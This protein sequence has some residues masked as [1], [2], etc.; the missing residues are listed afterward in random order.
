MEATRPV[1]LCVL[2]CVGLLPPVLA[3][4][5]ISGDPKTQLLL[6][7]SAAVSACGFL[8]TKWLVPLVGAKTASRGIC[9]KD[10]N[11]R[12]TP[13]GERPVPEA[14]GLAVG[15]VFLLCII[16]FELLHYYDIGS[17]VRWLGS[18]GQ[19]G[20]I[21]MEQT[22][23]AWLVDY[24]AAMATICFML[25]LGFADDVLDIRCGSGSRMPLRVVHIHVT[26]NVRLGR[27]QGYAHHLLTASTL[28]LRPKG[29]S[30][31][32]CACTLHRACLP[33]LAPALYVR[34]VWRAMLLAWPGTCPSPVLSS[35]SE[36]TGSLGSDPSF[37]G[38]YHMQGSAL[39]RMA[40]PPKQ[41]QF[42]C[43]P[44]TTLLHT[45]GLD[46]ARCAAWSVKP[47]PALH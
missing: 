21:R 43:T 5:Q 28:P 4:C 47:C 20:A 35:M 15:C 9:G 27:A 18:G 32:N 36:R 33:G 44:L 29:A 30:A 2:A 34:A 25:F 37:P 11:K 6:A 26:P 38:V 1:Q 7:T 39:H 3:F 24:N 17:L 40:P 22:P 19:Q 16:C 31:V 8:A 23:D 13:L 14:G 12:G 42:C 45:P 46:L 10:L 41:L